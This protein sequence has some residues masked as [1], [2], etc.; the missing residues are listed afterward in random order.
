[1]KRLVFGIGVWGEIKEGVGETVIRMPNKIINENSRRCSSYP[2]DTG[3]SNNGKKKW[4]TRDKL[5]VWGFTNIIVLQISVDF[6]IDN[7][8]WR[9]TST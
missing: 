5:A 7:R 9:Y 2:W 3:E 1:M 8:H 6:H 4:K